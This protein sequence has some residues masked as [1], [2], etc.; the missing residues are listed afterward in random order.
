VEFE[1][2]K[3]GKSDSRLLLE[4]EGDLL[5]AKGAEL[6]SLVNYK[7]AAL[8]LEREEGSLLLSH[9]IEVMEKEK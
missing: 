2:F 1:R 5:E 9:G 6:E 3:A 8:E 7:K 4:R